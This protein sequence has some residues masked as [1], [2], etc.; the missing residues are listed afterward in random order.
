MIDFS[1]RRRRIISKSL[2][3]VYNEPSDIPRF[4][5]FF[6]HIDHFRTEYFLWITASGISAAKQ[7]KS[8]SRNDNP[9]DDEE[10]DANGEEG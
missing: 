8:V 1:G 10:A 9:S 4:H 6:H 7:S 3:I 5:A 2:E